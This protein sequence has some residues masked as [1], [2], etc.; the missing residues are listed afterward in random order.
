MF[1]FVL[2]M[3]SHVDCFIADAATRGQP[4]MYSYMS[5]GWSCWM[6]DQQMITDM[7]GVKFNRTTKSRREYC[8]QRGIAKTVDR[9]GYIFAQMQFAEPRPFKDRKLTANYFTCMLQFCPNLRRRS[10]GELLQT[11]AFDGALK[12]AMMKL[13]HARKELMYHPDGPPL[14][15]CD[16]TL[17][18]DMD[19]KLLANKDKDLGIKCVSHGYSNGSKWGMSPFCSEDLLDALHL[20]ISSAMDNSSSLVDNLPLFITSCVIYKDPDWYGIYNDFI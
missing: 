9:A 1:S 15:L 4:I 5:D 18:D 2:A 19:K 12:S 11:Y 14:R 7:S 6:H 20:A 8:L 17:A 3:A 16:G 13:V 10:S